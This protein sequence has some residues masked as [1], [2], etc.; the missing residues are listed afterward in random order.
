MIIFSQLPVKQPCF[1]RHDRQ[2][3]WTTEERGPTRC[4]TPST[5]ELHLPALP[6]RPPSRPLSSLTSPIPDFPFFVSFVPSCETPR[7]PSHPA[8][9]LTR[10]HEDT[11]TIRKP[12]LLRRCLLPE[13][14]TSRLSHPAHHPNLS[15][16][17]PHQ[18]LTFPSSCPSCLR[19]RLAGP[20]HTVRSR[21]TRRRSPH[22]HPPRPRQLTPEQI[23]ELREILTIGTDIADLVELL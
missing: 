16:L 15:P 19:V 2:R 13:S 5:G 14:F 17:P 12:R 21:L 9:R 8:I 6:A 11:K 3:S 7:S 20:R 22:C 23:L 10:S 18:S 4:R 1:R